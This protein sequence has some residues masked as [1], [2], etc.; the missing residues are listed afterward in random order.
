MYFCTIDNKSYNILK[1]LEIYNVTIIDV[2]EVTEGILKDIRVGRNDKEYC[3][4]L[5][6]IFIEHILSNYKIE[7]ILYSDADMFFF[8][9]I[10]H[11]FKEWG[12]DSFFVCT[13]RASEKLE[14]NYGYYQGGLIGFKNNYNGKKILTWLKEKCINWCYDTNDYELERWSDQK[15]LNNI[16]ILFDSIKVSNNIGINAAPWNLILN[17]KCYIF[18]ITDEGLLINNSMLCA[19]HFNSINIYDIKNFDL[20][21]NSPVNIDNGVIVNIYNPYISSLNITVKRLIGLG[22]EVNPLYDKEDLLHAKN[23]YKWVD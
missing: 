11:I 13:K 16:P 12:E 3:W 10:K 20:W 5:K 19:Y 6:Y 4:T 9:N 8:T 14:Y 22:I 2:N 1:K 7:S 18:N 21:T 23:Y 17:N 15:Y